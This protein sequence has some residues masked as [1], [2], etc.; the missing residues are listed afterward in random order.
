[1]KARRYKDDSP[2]T[3]LLEVFFKGISESWSGGI[4]EINEFKN[5]LKGFN[6]VLTDE[7]NG[8]W[9]RKDATP[10]GQ[11]YSLLNGD[12]EVQAVV[13]SKMEDSIL[14]RQWYDYY[15]SPSFKDTNDF[16]KRM[17][18]KGYIIAILPSKEVKVS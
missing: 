12:E 16:V 2:E 14:E 4:R 5:K 3:I 13:L 1:M 8:K 18:K 6:V 17:E 10:I 15:W 11:L 7:I 9:E